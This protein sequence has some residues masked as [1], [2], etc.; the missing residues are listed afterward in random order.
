MKPC[1]YTLGAHVCEEVGDHFC[2][3]RADHAQRFIES[4]LMH[5]KGRYAR[6]RFVLADWQ[7]DGIIRPLFGTAEWSDEH[8]CYRRRYSVAWIE[9]GRKALDVETLILTD[10]GWMK[11]ADVAVGD[12]VFGPDG[13]LTTV[14]FASETFTE[15]TFEVTSRSGRR[16]VAGPDHEWVVGD[17]RYPR[18]A[19]RQPDGTRQLTQ[20]SD[21]VVT[22]AELAENLR[23]RDGFRYVLP[24]AAAVG[25]EECELPVDPYCLGAWLGDGTS[26]SGAMTAHEDDQPFMRAQFEAAGYETRSTAHP[27]V[28]YVQKL[29]TDL[30]QLGVLHNKHIPELYLTASI[31]Q[32]MAL[33]R[34]L[35]DTDGWMAE[36]GRSLVAGF[37][38][39][40][41]EFVADVQ[42]LAR[43]LGYT[44]SMTVKKRVMI[45][46]KE[47]GP[48]YE[49][50]WTL[51]DDPMP[52]RMPRKASKVRRSTYR[53]QR[54]AITSV[55]PAGIRQTRCIG[56]EGDVFLAG[57]DL[58]PTGNCGKSEILAAIML[59]VFFCDGEYAAELYSVATDRKQ[60][61]LIFDVATAMI[62]FNPSLAKM[63]KIVPSQKRIIKLNSNSVY[64]VLANDAAS[65]L[66]SN[67]SAVAADEILAWRDGGMWDAM[68]TG[69]G[70]MARVQPLLVAAT[71]AGNSLESFG[72]TEHNEMAKIVEDPDRAPHVFVYMRNTP[73]DA[74]PF[75]ESNW[76]HACPALGDFLSLEEFRKMAREARNNP[77]K[78]N[79][80]RQFQ[81]NQWVKQ[82]VAWM[83]MHLFD[84]SR[85][86][87]Y[88]SAADTMEQFAGRECWMGIDLAGRQDLTSVCYLFP[89]GDSCD[90]VWRHFCPEGALTRLDERNS[91]RFSREFVTEG[92]LTVTE[93]DVLDFEV[94]YAQIEE[95]SR[96][97]R[98]LGADMDVWSSAPVL[99]ALEDRLYTEI[100]AYAN[101]F[102]HMSDSMHRILELTTEKK[103]RWHG[104]P[105][106]RWCFDAV[107]ARIAA[108]DPNLIRP[109]K[110]NRDT[111]SKR[112]DAVPAAIMAVNAWQGRGTASTSYYADN[113]VMTL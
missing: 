79:G 41:R 110:P 49:L 90:V 50:R 99:Q 29:M 6:K 40:S 103:F 63:C 14:N 97:F 60:A 34:G 46:D 86:T 19:L 52:V 7:R 77:M 24:P 39:K 65:A 55:A 28:F 71:T 25:A 58:M 85:G 54:E 2:V 89:D 20:Y 5:T 3:P 111:E 76:Y 18:G 16:L 113:D 37:C 23:H 61:S 105:L 84:E 31:E 48:Y 44:P 1:G 95:D 70:S 93:G 69:M 94:V 82:S 59:T 62:R 67:P 11:L 96:R 109:D 4:G 47:Y 108:Y 68:R 10:R 30:R 42:L 57:R 9:L 36:K 92:W 112:I 64:Q 83:P 17:K 27:Q 106:A 15:P 88:R 12:R 104:N 51:G 91:G 101:D 8:D 43:S 73:M 22:T 66:G 21:V 78:L 53:A 80:F 32:R 100:F 75:D 81:L 38:G 74:D 26:K 35:M 98:I 72:G 56:V 45:G 13:Q 87:I 107:Q 33:L 102:K